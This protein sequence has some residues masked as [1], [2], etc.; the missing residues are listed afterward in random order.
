MAKTLTELLANESPEF[1]KEAQEKAD[2]MRLSIH[3]AK[4]RKQAKLTQIE[5]GSRLGLKQPTIASMEKE[6]QDIRLSS[7]KKYIEAM[8]G[9]VS[10]QIEM[11]NG[12][13]IGI[14][15]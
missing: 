2:N 7:L 1:I 3:L 14:T 12:E 6:G 5:L 13:Q 10:L 9:K 11:P 8:N 15:L 4:L